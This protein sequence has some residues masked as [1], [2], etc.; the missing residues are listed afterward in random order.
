MIA[1]R[2]GPDLRMAAVGAPAYFKKWSPPKKPQDLTEHD[3]I[4]LRLPTSGAIY[5]WEL[6]ENGKELE[7]AVNGRVVT[8]DGQLVDSI[9]EIAPAEA[10]RRRILVDNPAELYGF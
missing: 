10:T 8:N 1:V 5:R 6:N 2:I 4:N 9:A 3:C 7:V